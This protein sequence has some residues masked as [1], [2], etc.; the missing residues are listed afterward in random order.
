MQDFC[1]KYFVVFNTL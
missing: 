1:W